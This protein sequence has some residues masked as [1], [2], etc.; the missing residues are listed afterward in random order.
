MKLESIGT[1]APAEGLLLAGFGAC[2]LHGARGE[3]EGVAVPLEHGRSFSQCAQYRILRAGDRVLQFVPADLVTLVSPHRGAE[4][5][6][7]QL[8]AEADAEHGFV[9]PQ[10]GFDGLQFGGEVRV[11]VLVLDVHGPAQ[12]DEPAIA[13]EVRLRIGMAMKIVEADAMAAR[14]DARI[15][16]AQ[17]LGRNVLENHQSGHAGA[18]IGIRAKS[19][20]SRVSPQRCAYAGKAGSTRES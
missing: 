2:E 1:A 9:L 17:G 4:H 19:C 16:R 7:Q 11:A 10:R 14:A 18:T 12:H 3:V 13:V 8:R 20:N 5:M 15:Q 6:G